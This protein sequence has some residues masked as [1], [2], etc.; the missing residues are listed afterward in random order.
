MLTSPSRSAAELVLLV[1]SPTALVLCMVTDAPPPWRAT[2]AAV[3]FLLAPGLGVLAPLNLR[4]D[5]ELALTVPISLAVTSLV[6]MPL[7]YLRIWS[8]SLAV[9]VLVVVCARGALLVWAR[10][11]S[12][13]APAP[14]MAGVQRGDQ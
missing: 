6:S 2:A 7:F 9:A 1:V 14:A 12:G 10:S 13:A 4:I 3:F 8:G 5:L 11:S